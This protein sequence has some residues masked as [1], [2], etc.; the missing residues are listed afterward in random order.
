[1]KPILAAHGVSYS[2]GDAQLLRDI[3]LELEPGEIVG[4]IGPNGAGKSTLLRNLIG[5]ATPD[6]G[7]VTLKG[8]PLPSY[9]ARERS[10]TMSYLS[11]QGPDQFAFRAVDVVEMGTYPGLRWGRAPG[12]RERTSALSALAEVGLSELADREFPTLSEGER[13]LVLFARVLVQNAPVMLLDEPTANLDIG[14]EQTLLRTVRGLCDHEHAA[15]VALHNLNSAAEYCKR[16]ILLESGRVTSV[17]SPHEVLTRDNLERAYNTDVRIGQNETTGSI[18]VNSIPGAGARRNLRVHV[19]GGAGSAVGMTRFLHRKG[20][21]ITG[22]VAHELDSDA[23][24]WAALGID[25]LEVPAFSD[26]Q[27]DVI[28]RAVDFVHQAD[29]TILCAFPFGH[30]NAANLEIAEHA[31]ELLILDESTALCRRAFFGDAVN[32]EVRFR[33]LETIWGTVSYER[34]CSYIASMIAT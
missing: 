10:R 5:F 7:V 27:A 13:Q 12:S 31:R 1:M 6:S 15:V 20:C 21:T 8:R 32:L 24:F 2:V 23:K 14:H 19:I 9:S 3:S 34:A 28:E 22:G 11:R 29:L 30:G 16:L 18:T 17:G 4:L 33:Q 26:I 25:H